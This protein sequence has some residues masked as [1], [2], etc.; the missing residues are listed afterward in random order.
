MYNSPVPF[1]YSFVKL[2]TFGVPLTISLVCCCCLS[3][4]CE[5]ICSPNSSWTATEDCADERV[6][7]Q[8]Q[9]HWL[10]IEARSEG[11]YYFN[12]QTY[13]VS[14]LLISVPF[15]MRKEMA[16]SEF[17]SQMPHKHA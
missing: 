17:C 14:L 2:E 3:V 7:K 9:G 10:L 1:S 13:E 15:G 6:V 12:T 4:E 8:L 16:R 5:G 11:K